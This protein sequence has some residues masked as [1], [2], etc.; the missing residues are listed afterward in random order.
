VIAGLR[1]VRG[2]LRRDGMKTGGCRPL[3]LAG[4]ALAML[5]GDCRPQG[6][7]G[8]KGRFEFWYV[9]PMYNFDTPLI[10]FVDQ[11]TQVS[12]HAFQ[13]PP[14][15]CGGR[16][17]YSFSQVRSSDP[18]VATFTLAPD[19]SIALVTGAPGT[20]EL[21]LLD[22]RA[23]VVDSIAIEV[24]PIAGLTFPDHDAR[25]IA[26]GSYQ[27]DMTLL[28]AAGRTLGGGPGR[29]HHEVTGGLT[30]GQTDSFTG[31]TLAVSSPKVGTGSITATAE[32]VTHTLA[33]QSVDLAAVTSI[34]LGTGNLEPSYNPND[35]IEIV[36]VI[37]S[38]SAGPVFG[39]PC[40]WQIA[41]PSVQLMGN[42][43]GV[44]LAAQ[45]LNSSQFKLNKAGSFDAICTIGA[46][47]LT[48]T[49]KR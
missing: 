31:T 34:E 41:D 21:E 39:A 19:H 14:G 10:P 13:P 3:W 27:L 23:Q 8:T 15:G 12:L 37:P 47:R 46:A 26:G 48:V 28:D 49:L 7:S 29:I 2:L 16:T 9:E 18:Q 40:T 44:E 6:T 36:R 42:G 24:E 35:Q 11:G 45:P 30:T 33:V 4:L 17:T 20:A 43:T 38:T 25:I 1:V 22:D 5:G 32:T